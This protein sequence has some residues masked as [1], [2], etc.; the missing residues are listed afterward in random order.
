LKEQALKK[1][2]ANSI[3]FVFQ[4]LLPNNTGTDRAS[5]MA[6]RMIP[7][8]RKL[9]SYSGVNEPKA[10]QEAEFVTPYDVIQTG[11]KDNVSAFYQNISITTVPGLENAL[12]V[13]LKQS[14]ERLIKTL[15]SQLKKNICG[16]R[17]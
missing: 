1:D 5:P 16:I 2:I 3:T 17:L 12:T 14:E 6:S 13:G 9:I 15:T 8:K 10:L 11:I 4:A 7:G